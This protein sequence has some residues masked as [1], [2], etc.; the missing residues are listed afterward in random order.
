MIIEYLKYLA[1]FVLAILIQVLLFDNIYFMGYA[2]VFYYLIF[3]IMLPIKIN[4]YVLMSLGF[5]TGLFVDI[6]NSTIGMHA[7]ACVFVSFLRPYI[8]MIYSPRDGYEPENKPG[9]Y[10]YGFSW[11]F[12][13][14]ITIILIH[15]L[16]F[17]YIEVF[18]FYNFFFTFKKVILT[19]I[20][21]FTSI[22]LTLLLRLKK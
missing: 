1:L 14:A 9:L 17:Y 12:K 22:L 4:R 19:S 15:H 5:I 11:F 3:I 7:F 8:L 20:F 10:N 16:V 13:Y 6:F 18:R 2:N 21:S